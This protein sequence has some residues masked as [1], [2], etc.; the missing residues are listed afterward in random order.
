MSEITVD[1]DTL[2]RKRTVDFQNLQKLGGNADVRQIKNLHNQVA[3][4]LDNFASRTAVEIPIFSSSY[5]TGVDCFVKAFS[6][7]EDSQFKDVGE[8]EVAL[9]SMQ[10]LMGNLESARESIVTFAGMVRGLPRTTTRFVQARKR[11]TKV[12]DDLIAEMSTAHNLGQ[13]LVGLLT[14]LKSRL[15]NPGNTEE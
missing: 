12:L 3:D 9:T 10:G 2:I 5:A 7:M 8:V 6:M 14:R 15:I 4:D 1:L 13:E 11:A